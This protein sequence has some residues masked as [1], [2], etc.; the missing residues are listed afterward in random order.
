MDKRELVYKCA[1]M[2]EKYYDRL[3]GKNDAHTV[4]SLDT[5]DINVG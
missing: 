1:E 4:Y 5:E 3:S 2:F